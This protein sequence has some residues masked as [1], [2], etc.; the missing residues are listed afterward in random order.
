MIWRIELVR[1]FVECV[2]PG[3]RSCCF[4]WLLPFRYWPRWLATWRTPKRSGNQAFLQFF[5]RPLTVP[6]IQEQ[7]RRTITP[8]TTIVC[9]VRAFATQ[10]A[11]RLPMD[12]WDS[13]RQ[14]HGSLALF[15]RSS[16][17]HQIPEKLNAIGQERLRPYS[18]AWAKSPLELS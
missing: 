12:S 16:T 2:D 4:L 8:P 15:R 17:H 1:N 3:F 10:S 14:T 9:F 5:V 6:I 18:R 13:S 11:S 7:V